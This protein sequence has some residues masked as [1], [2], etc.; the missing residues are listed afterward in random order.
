MKNNIKMDKNIYD[1]LNDVTVDENEYT[2]NNVDE[3]RKKRIIKNFTKRK[4]R[5]KSNNKRYLV[6]ASIALLLVTTTVTI[7]IGQTF[8]AEAQA[9]IYRMFN[10]NG[11]DV[12]EYVNTVDKKAYTVI[13]PT[14]YGKREV[15]ETTMVDLDYTF[16]YKGAEY[17]LNKLITNSK[18]TFVDYSWVYNREIDDFVLP[19]FTLEGE[20]NLGREI[21]TYNSSYS[22]TPPYGYATLEIVHPEV[23]DENLKGITINNDINQI[24]LIPKERVNAT[25]FEKPNEIPLKSGEPIGEEFSVNLTSGY[26]E[27]LPKEDITNDLDVE[28]NDVVISGEELLF[29]YNIKNIKN[30]DRYKNVKFLA[31]KVYVNGKLLATGPSNDNT[32]GN[33]FTQKARRFIIPELKD[34]KGEVDLKLEFLAP[35]AELT[36]DT[37]YSY[38]YNYAYL[39][40]EGK[41]WVFE[42][43]VDTDAIK[44]NTKVIPINKTFD[45]GNITLSNFEITPIR[46]VINYTIKG[47][48]NTFDTYVVEGYDDLGNKIV[49]GGGTMSILDDETAEVKYAIFD[50]TR[51]TIDSFGGVNAN[52]K[53]LYLT[54]YKLNGYTHN[55]EKKLTEIVEMTVKLD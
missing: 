42:T 47:N 1:Y 54:L 43:T 35:L 29:T 32:V 20:D 21:L 46:A 36:N 3:L 18:G 50:E 16:E 8:I 5:K 15:F 28:L 30:L 13:E 25:I 52:A 38:T 9:M 7:D 23:M 4:K 49:S 10:I 40:E 14:N 33:I 51:S 45:N 2:I 53:E 22:I 39:A 6:A 44:E 11:A 17:T 31:V 12:E 55:N 24:T 48:S 41:M 37:A 34:L 26:T 19:G 27:M